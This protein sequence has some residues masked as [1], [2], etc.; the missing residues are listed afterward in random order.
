MVYNNKG[1]YMS[2]EPVETV[3]DRVARIRIILK[4]SPA[5]FADALCLSRSY[6]YGLEK[7]HRI[8]NDRIVK[9]V[10]MTFGVGEQWL[11]TG[12]GIMFKDA[13]DV[14]RRK[15]EILFKKLRPDFQEYVLR[16]IDLLLKL[17]DKCGE[18]D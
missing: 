3:N 18:N 5:E 14:T 2:K 11:K 6:I 12:K 8:A 16:H 17:Q 7:K 10:S 9:L 4:M 13:E 15:I 1:W